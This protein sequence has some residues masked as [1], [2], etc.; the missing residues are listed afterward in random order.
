MKT[1]VTNTW[2][3]MPGVLLFA[4]LVAYPCAAAAQATD[5][6]TV[7][8]ARD[9]A[10]NA[11]DLEAALEFY[12][13]GATIRDANPDPGST[14]VVEGKDKIREFIAD[15]ISNKIRLE[16]ANFQVAGDTVNFEHHV[17][18]NDPDLIRLNLLPIET[19]DTVVVRDGKIH[20]WLID[21]KQE[22]LLRAE[23]AFAADQ[24]AQAG[25][26]RT[27]AFDDGLAQHAWMS[28]VSLLVVVCGAALRL[29]LGRVRLEDE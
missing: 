27:G 16:P 3:I 23:T 25:M 11:G 20:D 24:G 6:V 2:A 14:G 15:A 13:D 4:T 17:W 7:I 1:K 9:A 21:I 29:T 22:W 5:P 28:I 19:N 8:Q 26:P 18:R 12:A 10:V